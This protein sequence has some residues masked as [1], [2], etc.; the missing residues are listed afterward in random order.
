MT[1]RQGRRSGCVSQHARDADALLLWAATDDEMVVMDIGQFE[2]AAE[3]GAI[4]QSSW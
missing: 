3:D 2:F 4:S 1:P